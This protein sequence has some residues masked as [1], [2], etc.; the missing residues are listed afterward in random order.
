MLDEPPTLPP[1]PPPPPLLLPGARPPVPGWMWAA[2]GT[3]LIPVCALIFMENVA[4]YPDQLGA[5]AANGAICGAILG[6]PMLGG[7]ALAGR[8]FKDTGARVAMGVVFAFIIMVGLLG[9]L[10]A[11]CIYLMSRSH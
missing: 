9:L 6:L 8:F 11:G 2:F 4:S 10:F 7:L 5:A 1:S 3:G